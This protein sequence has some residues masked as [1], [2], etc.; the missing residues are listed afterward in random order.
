M[1]DKKHPRRILWAVERIFESLSERVER[2]ELLEELNDI[3]KT[4]L[5]LFKLGIVQ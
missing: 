1:L 3:S 2:G 4:Y 5:L